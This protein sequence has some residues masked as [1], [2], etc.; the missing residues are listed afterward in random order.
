MN[1][2]TPKLLDMTIDE[3]IGI[4]R[5]AKSLIHREALVWLCQLAQ[6]APDGLGIELGVYCGSSLI[7]WSLMRAGLG[8]AIG[9]D[10]WSYRDIPNLKARCERNL[11][12]ASVEV[13]LLDMDSAEAAAVVLD[14]IAFLHIDANHSRPFVEQDITLWTPKVMPGGIVAFHDY[15]RFRPDC[16]VTEAVDAWQGRE[17]WERLG[18]VATMIG[19]RKP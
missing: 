19:F 17:P 18:E 1:S 8:Q 2:S 9:V 10:N 7:A 6:M 14:P 5:R 16:Q 3:I 15:G 4:A 12:A 11:D 13:Q